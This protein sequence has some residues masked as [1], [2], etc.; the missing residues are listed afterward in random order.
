MERELSDWL[1]MSG[2]IPE[3]FYHDSTAAAAGASS[4]PE[5]S[6]RHGEMAGFG[7]RGEGGFRGRIGRSRRDVSPGPYM[8]DLSTKFAPPPK[9]FSRSTY[10]SSTPAD[11]PS[12]GS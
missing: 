3:G 12:E 1:G 10:I 6:Q 9:S 4:P 7:R 5:S 11:A 8:K 2:R